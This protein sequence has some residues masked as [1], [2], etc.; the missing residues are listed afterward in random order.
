MINVHVMQNSDTIPP[1]F[2]PDADGYQIAG[3][4]IVGETVSM[5]AW[6]SWLEL[7]LF[8]SAVVLTAVL[9][10][11]RKN[12]R[13]LC[14]FAAA[15]MIAVYQVYAL[16]SVLFM[17]SEVAFKILAPALRFVLWSRWVGPLLLA[18]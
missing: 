8:V 17:Q 14:L 11:R 15:A 4:G 3:S 6:L 13:S 10:I 18:V 5:P 16:L 2:I 12:L 7:V 1:E 9:L